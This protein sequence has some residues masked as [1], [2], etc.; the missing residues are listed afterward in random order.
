M[1]P[2]T[3]FASKCS[4]FLAGRAGGRAA[5]AARDALIGHTPDLAALFAG[6]LGYKEE[7]DGMSE[8]GWH[9]DSDGKNTFDILPAATA[10]SR[11]AS[12]DKA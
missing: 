12:I 9:F 6:E 5:V 10:R 7:W 1:G 11:R 3:A 2:E 4:G 8:Q